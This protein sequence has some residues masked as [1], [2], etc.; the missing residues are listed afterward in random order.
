MKFCEL[1]ISEA[2]SDVPTQ[3]AWAW[4]SY[5]N[6][7]WNECI[8]ILDSDIL[9]LD[10]C[11]GY[12]LAMAYYHSGDQAK[13]AQMLQET[14]LLEGSTGKPT[15]SIELPRLKWEARGLLKINSSENRRLPEK[16]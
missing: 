7:R 8:A 1:A 15:R 11:N 5:R 2:P 3:Q 13:A 6:G 12:V 4:A 10:P 9:R 16:E 14:E